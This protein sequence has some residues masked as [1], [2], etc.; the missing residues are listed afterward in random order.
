MD[1]VGSLSAW[2]HHSAYDS[3]EE[4]E[5]ARRVV[6]HLEE[7]EAAKVAHES[8]RWTSAQERIGD[9][10]QIA[11]AETMANERMRR[12][13]QCIATDDPRLK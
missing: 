4:C 5:R 9:A 8:Q 11:M 10:M 12:E 7:V 2:T 6:F 1:A 3:A 13:S